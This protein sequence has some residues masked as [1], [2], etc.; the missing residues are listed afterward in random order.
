M[1]TLFISLFILIL[2]G[3]KAQ[4][5]S[6]DYC[7]VIK[8]LNDTLYKYDYEVAF[9]DST[10]IK[11]AEK[12]RYVSGILPDWN[13]EIGYTINGKNYPNRFYVAAISNFK[14]DLSL[15]AAY[16]EC[17][18]VAIKIDSGDIPS[19]WIQ[20]RYVW[21]HQNTLNVPLLTYSYRFYFQKTIADNDSSYT[22]FNH[23]YQLRDSLHNFL[24]RHP[25]Q[26]PEML[27]DMAL[28]SVM[29]FI[30][31]FMEDD[32]LYSKSYYSQRRLL[33]QSIRSPEIIL[34]FL[35]NFCDGFTLS[36]DSIDKEKYDSGAYD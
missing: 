25:R 5:D 8:T 19:D 10:L 20:H 12:L 1:R 21:S 35:V 23:Y 13:P 28:D 2:F 17:N 16:F 24:M 34:Y 3:V 11:K 6:C 22:S 26:K 4:K 15:M 30:L 18:D 27:W 29:P 7:S 33:I 36:F 9:W 31:Y 14:C 32:S